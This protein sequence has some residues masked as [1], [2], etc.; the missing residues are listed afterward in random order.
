MINKTSNFISKEYDIIIVPKLEKEHILMNDRLKTKAARSIGMVPNNKIVDKIKQKA[1]ERNKKI[2]IPK[3][4]YTTQTC[5]KCGKIQDIK[6]NE[7]YKC[8]KCKFECDRD[9]NSALGILLR[10]V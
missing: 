8:K 1:L 5:T 3:E 6:E 2:I 10:L 9:L 7:I 4:Y